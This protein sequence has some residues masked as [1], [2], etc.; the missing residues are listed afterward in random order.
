M[1]NGCKFLSEK[2]QTITIGYK[3]M[4]L[5]VRIK[6][7]IFGKMPDITSPGRIDFFCSN[8]EV[9]KKVKDIGYGSLIENNSLQ[10]PM[11]IPNKGSIWCDGCQHYCSWSKES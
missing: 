5:L 2:V 4:P 11:T 3:D 6:Q 10:I 8:P 9:L 1:K 7:K